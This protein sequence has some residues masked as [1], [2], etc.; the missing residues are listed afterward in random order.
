MEA[1]HLPNGSA[2]PAV[3]PEQAV[4]ALHPK[5]ATSPLAPHHSSARPP[6]PPSPLQF[7]STTQSH[8]VGQPQ[9]QTVA[10]SAS[11]SPTVAAARRHTFALPNGVVAGA[12]STYRYAVPKLVIW[13]TLKS[14]SHVVRLSNGISVRKLDI[15]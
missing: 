1:G 11:A 10:S 15:S 12:F 9:V 7:L 13:Y 8:A 14:L 4:D 6:I 2:Q 3:N 5:A